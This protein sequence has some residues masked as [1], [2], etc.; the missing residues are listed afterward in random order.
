M[1]VGEGWLEATGWN[2]SRKVLCKDGVCQLRI[3][4]LYLSIPQPSPAWS[5]TPPELLHPYPPPYD[6]TSPL[7]SCGPPPNLCF[8][9]PPN[10]G[11]LPPPPLPAF[12]LTIPCPGTPLS[13]FL[14]GPPIPTSPAMGPT[15]A[16]HLR[17][18]VVLLSTKAAPPTH[19]SNL[20]RLLPRHPFSD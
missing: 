17:T 4:T 5:P 10:L 15:F 16:L 12:L 18:F 2:R 6:S 14:Y 7:I 11:P 13:S 20:L 8:V 3:E 9:S 19:N 1:Q